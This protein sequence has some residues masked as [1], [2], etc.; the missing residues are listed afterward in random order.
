MRVGLE[1]E[2]SAK[3]SGL[4]TDTAETFVELKYVE[5]ELSNVQSFAVVAALRQR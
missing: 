5:A 2:A 1:P 3:D 4:D